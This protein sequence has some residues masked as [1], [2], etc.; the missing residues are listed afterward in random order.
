MQG[1]CSVDLTRNFTLAQEA[2]V[3]NQFTWSHVSQL[4]YKF[5]VQSILQFDFVL[6]P[7]AVNRIDLGVTVA[8]RRQGEYVSIDPGARPVSWRV[9]QREQKES[10]QGYSFVELWGSLIGI[11]CSL[12]IES[13]E[14]PDPVLA[15]CQTNVLEFPLPVCFSATLSSSGVM[16]QPFEMTWFVII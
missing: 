10:L 4:L 6:L 8:V 11:V 9:T 14:D 7:A 12:H 3:H 1:K 16:D 2:A 13:Y 15:A 5:H